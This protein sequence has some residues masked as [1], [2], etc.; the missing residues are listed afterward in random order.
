MEDG[1]FDSNP[2]AGRAGKEGGS[3]GPPFRLIL[4]ASS[5]SFTRFSA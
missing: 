5:I 2:D 1:R 4:Q 3:D